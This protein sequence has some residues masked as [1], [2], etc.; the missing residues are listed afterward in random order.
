MKKFLCACALVTVAFL[1]TG[2]MRVYE[3][4]TV[5]DNETVTA[6]VKQ[7]ILKSTSDSLN[8]EKDPN[9]IEE[10]LEDGNTYY[11]QTETKEYPSVAEFSKES[12]G[13]ISKD[14]FYVD[15]NNGNSKD[16]TS[17]EQSIV[18]LVNQSI[19][20]KMT[21]NLA[22]EIVET[23]ANVKEET[24]GNTAVFDTKFLS[25]SW[26][27]Y[28][29]HGKELIEADVTAPVISNVEEGGH[30]CRIPDIQFSDDTAV[31]SKTI[32]GKSYSTSN[33]KDGLNTLTVT[34]VKGNSTTVTFYKDMTAPVI[35][36]IKNGK[37]YKGKVLFYVK[38]KLELDTVTDNGKKLKLTKKNLVKSGK[39]KNYYKFEIKKKGKHKIIAIDK[40]GNRIKYTIRIR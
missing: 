3:T 14:I 21:I 12:S 2:C 32:N 10:V 35:K 34:D 13:N 15:L 9:T 1:S 11:T 28:T 19:Y 8:S 20:I 33:I 25:E 7:A 5:N 37:S 30:Y 36:K 18:D 6:T 38:D 17:T 31:A 40:A 26:Y 39:Y 24:K 16:A 27:A 23:N 22:G 29:A 4:I